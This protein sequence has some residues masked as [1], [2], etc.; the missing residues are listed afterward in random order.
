MIYSNTRKYDGSFSSRSS[1]SSPS[2]QSTPSTTP[3]NSRDSFLSN[4]NLRSQKH[5][6]LDYNVGITL[7]TRI[8]QQISA[9][10]PGSYYCPDHEVVCN[11]GQHPTNM[12]YICKHCSKKDCDTFHHRKSILNQVQESE[13][14]RRSSSTPALNPITSHSKSNTKNSK[15][16]SYCRETSPESRP[17]HHPS[18]R[19]TPSSERNQRFVKK[20][21]PFHDQAV[22][23]KTVQFLHSSSS[24]KPVYYSNTITQYNEPLERP[25]EFQKQYLQRG[26]FLNS[27]FFQADI[28]ED[29]DF[30]SDSEPDQAKKTQIKSCMKSSKKK[31]SNRIAVPFHVNPFS[32]NHISDNEYLFEEDGDSETID[33][34]CSRHHQERVSNYVAHKFPNIVTFQDSSPVSSTDNVGVCSATD[35]TNVSAREVSDTEDSSDDEYYEPRPNLNSSTLSISDPLSSSC[36]SSNPDS[37]ILNL[38]TI[39]HHHETSSTTSRNSQSVSKS[40]HPLNLS[41]LKQHRKALSYSIYQTRNSS[42]SAVKHAATFPSVPGSGCSSSSSSCYAVDDINI[43][44]PNKASNQFSPSICQQGSLY[45]SLFVDPHHHSQAMPGEK[46]AQ[47][48]PTSCSLAALES[49]SFSVNG[50]HHQS[51]HKALFGRNKYFSEKV[52]TVGSMFHLKKKIVG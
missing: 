45:Q 25:V 48:P 6:R 49:T 14:L 24:P 43:S 52:K 47:Q 46:Q 40:Q 38:N 16:E 44:Q 22:R 17:S 21:E 37:H 2:T 27:D 30:E 26:R 12:S 28:N 5:P 4:S 20:F 39:S 1:L 23:T 33:S 34:D 42:Q 32:N 18:Y 41:A 36:T 8:C 29:S 7:Y 51:P 19:R 50:I 13:V 11:A 10:T 3:S 31:K 9:H 15:S 35:F